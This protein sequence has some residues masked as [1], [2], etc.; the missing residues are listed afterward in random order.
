MI[1]N[2]KS[3]LVLAA[4]ALAILPLASCKEGH[5]LYENMGRAEGIS[6]YTTAAVGYMSANPAVTKFIDQNEMKLMSQGMVTSIM[7][8]SSMPMPND[9]VDLHEFFKGQGLDQPAIDGIRDA[10]VK[11]GKDVALTPE[12]EKQLRSAVDGVLKGL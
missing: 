11:A 7:K 2:L 6:K 5:T 10:A 12:G 9:G 4:A 1:R 8:A 3:V